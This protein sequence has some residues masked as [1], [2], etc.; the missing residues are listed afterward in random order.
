M[1]VVLV[2]ALGLLA[3]GC[4][5]LDGRLAAEEGGGPF[6][7]RTTVSVDLEPD[8][9]EE[10]GENL[11][12]LTEWI[13]PAT[14][15]WRQETVDCSRSRNLYVYSDRRFSSLYEGHPRDVR[16]GSPAFLAPNV[17]D[18]MSLR[19]IGSAD[20]LQVGEVLHGRAATGIAYSVKVEERIPLSEARRRGLFRVRVEEGD[21]LTRELEPGARPTLP[22][23]AYWFGPALA[24]RRAFAAQ[25]LR[26]DDGVLHI[27]CYGDPAEIAAKKTHCL[28]SRGEPRRE[29]QVVSQSLTGKLAQRELARLER[30]GPGRPIHLSNGEQA[31]LYR[32][33]VV[34]STTLITISGSLNL[35]RHAAT[36]RAL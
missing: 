20:D 4:W 24:G 9:Q 22:V 30:A 26:N 34:T 3:T 32:R 28:P 19:V 29:F 2:L 14:G 8:A 11:P 33:G 23:K 18:S 10:C 1:K 21:W 13:A 27:T 12:Q 7:Y 31:V 16:I 35:A 6:A 15:S 25:E 5:S 36:L 17:D